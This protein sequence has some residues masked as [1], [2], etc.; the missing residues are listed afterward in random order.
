MHQYLV[1]V[2]ERTASAARTGGGARRVAS[3]A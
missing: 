3:E 1:C 2:T